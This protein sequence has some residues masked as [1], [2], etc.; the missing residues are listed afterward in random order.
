M[1]KA[2]FTRLFCGSKA[3][4]CVIFF[5]FL[6]NIIIQIKIFF[7]CPLHKL[8]EK[9][10]KQTVCEAL[11][12]CIWK[13]SI[14]FLTRWIL[15]GSLFY[16]LTV[17]LCNV[18]ATNFIIIFKTDLLEAGLAFLKNCRSGLT[19]LLSVIFYAFLVINN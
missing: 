16:V 8:R 10:L 18:S 7:H 14:S 19:A 12:F 3:L 1:L 2:S 9:D 4:F 15:L 6:I 13:L 5:A 17:S 11:N